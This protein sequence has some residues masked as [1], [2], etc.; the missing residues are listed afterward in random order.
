MVLKQTNKKTGHLLRGPRIIK[1]GKHVFTSAAVMGWVVTTGVIFLLS[2]NVTPAFAACTPSDTGSA[3]ADV[4][5]C[6]ALNDPMGAN[7]TGLAGDDTITMNGGTASSID[8]GLDNDTVII[9][10]LA[11]VTGDVVMGTGADVFTMN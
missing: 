8:A 3:G 5:L 10:G 6:D 7:V 9:D 11:V 1:R 2:I 4:I